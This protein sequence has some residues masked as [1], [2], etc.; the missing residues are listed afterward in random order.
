M[1]ASDLRAGVLVT[2]RFPGY[3][4][5]PGVRY[6]FPKGKYQ[7]AIEQLIGSLVLFYEPRRGGH[8]QH[9]ATGGRSAF[10]S[11]AYIKAV[12]DDP[13]D[14]SHGFAELRFFMEFNSIVRG[15][16]TAI[17][18]ASLQTAVKLIP[19]A[20]AKRIVTLGISAPVRFGDTRIGL[21]DMDALTGISER[22]FREVITNKAV[23]DAS[24]RYRVVDSAYDGRCALTGVRMTN[25]NGRAE[26]D[27]AHIQAVS[28]G[29]PDTVRNGIALMKSLHWAFDRGLI[30]MA[31]DGSILTV[32]R[33]IDEP[34]RRLLSPT[35]KAFLPTAA[36]MRPHPA[37][38]LW[39]RTSRFKGEILLRN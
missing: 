13:D 27:A 5:V 28:E 31:D 11:F 20:E 15:D 24:F 35:G 14:R 34:V 2:R 36:D 23:R 17:P 29:G 7:S 25:G 39:H 16:E 12:N 19:F 8:S 21:T 32:D 9:S 18:L 6:H 4:D 22:E 37:F 33:G 10:T 38:L 3:K 26:A 30:S 1:T